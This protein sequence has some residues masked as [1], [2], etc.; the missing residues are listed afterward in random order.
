MTM[1]NTTKE[2][3]TMSLDHFSDHLYGT[4]AQRAE[5]GTPTIIRMG[6]WRFDQYA[7]NDTFGSV[8]VI[9]ATERKAYAEL[10]ALIAADKVFVK[11]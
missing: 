5:H 1:T 7:D 4:D 3:T 8:V 6:T 11:R 10:E 9:A 2:T